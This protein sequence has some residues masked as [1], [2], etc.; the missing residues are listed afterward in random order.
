MVARHTVAGCQ[1]DTSEFLDLRQLQLASSQQAGQLQQLRAE[2]QTA[3][4]QNAAAVEL[5]LIHI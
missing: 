2:L 3:L 5:S 4:A 1:T